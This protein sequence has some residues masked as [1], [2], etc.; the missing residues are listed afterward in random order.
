VISKKRRIFSVEFRLES[1]QL[2]AD[3]NYSIREAAQ[4]V[5]VGHATMDNWFRQLRQERDGVTPTAFAMTPEHRR[6]KDLE[7]KLRRI[8]KH[9]QL[10]SVSGSTNRSGE[11]RTQRHG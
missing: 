4:A 2:V 3:K 11:N 7:K 1:A 10:S 8:E 5:G 6:I 9:I